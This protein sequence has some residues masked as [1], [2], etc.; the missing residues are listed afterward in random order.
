MKKYFI[1]FLCAALFSSTLTGCSA[2]SKASHTAVIELSGNPSTG[3]TWIYEMSEDNIVREVKNEFQM[4]SPSDRVGA[5][6]KFVFEFEGISPGEVTLTFSYLR[7]FED[8]PPVKTAK[9]I[10]SVDND[11][12]VTLTE[13]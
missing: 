11:L 8:N 4:P 13:G 5:G 3:Y 2:S 7:T 10:I 6:G 12:N 1:F 9:Y